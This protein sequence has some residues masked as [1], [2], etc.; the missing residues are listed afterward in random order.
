MS[1]PLTA[2]P[3]LLVVAGLTFGSLAATDRVDAAVAG[4]ASDPPT[5]PTLVE[6]MQQLEVDMERVA[7]GVWLARFD[8]I[9]AG[10]QAVA[11]HPKIGPEERAQIM[12]ILGEGAEGFRQADMLV[13]NAAVELAD[14][15]RAGEMGGVLDALTRLQAGCVACHTGYRASIQEHAGP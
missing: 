8:S 9:A 14:R 4:A 2:V 13:H 1:V 7:H 15:A 3:R 10:A 5:Q 11:D 12:E 6:I